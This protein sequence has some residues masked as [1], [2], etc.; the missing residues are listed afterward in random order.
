ML[1]SLV[2]FVES[3]LFPTCKI[4]MAFAYF[5]SFNTTPVCQS[6]LGY[7]QWPSSLTWKISGMSRSN[8]L[9]MWLKHIQN[10]QGLCYFLLE[11]LGLQLYS[12]HSMYNCIWVPIEAKLNSPAGSLSPLM[13]YWWPVCLA[14]WIAKPIPFLILCALNITDTKWNNFWCSWYFSPVSAHF[15][16]LS[17]I[18]LIDLFQPTNKPVEILLALLWICRSVWGERTFLQYW[19]FQ[20]VNKVCPSISCLS[21]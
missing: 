4:K 1:S 6:S 5:R 12:F 8:H 17:D 10:A 11:Y 21:E 13:W 18:S 19:V 9:D 14:C 7:Q 3:T 2:Q 15:G 16:G 20:S